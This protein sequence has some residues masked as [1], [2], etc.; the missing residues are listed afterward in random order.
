MD[1]SAVILPLLVFILF[2]LLVF[3]FHTLISEYLEWAIEGVLL[4]I[5]ASEA[6]RIFKYQAVKQIEKE[7]RDSC[8]KE[9]V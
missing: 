5:L 4:A 7:S 1:D 9:R 2:I 3:G 6:W 8:K